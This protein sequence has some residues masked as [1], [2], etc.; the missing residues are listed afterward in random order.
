M[1]LLLFWNS[2][3]MHVGICGVFSSTLDVITSKPKQNFPS[4]SLSVL[5]CRQVLH[6]N[7]LSHE[8][9]FI[10]GHSVTQPACRVTCFKNVFHARDSLVGPLS[11]PL[12]LVRSCLFSL[13]FMRIFS[14]FHS[15]ILAA[16]LSPV[17]WVVISF[18]TMLVPLQCLLI[19]DG[20][21]SLLVGISW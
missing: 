18:F 16:P 20:E 2:C 19:L 8:L 3:M 5:P 11:L 21:I 7:Y 1:S 4:P 10:I 17:S 12:V 14:V 15:Q 13:I 6:P 9:A